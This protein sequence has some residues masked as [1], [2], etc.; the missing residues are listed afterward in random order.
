M[1]YDN[2]Y[3]LDVD[4]VIEAIPNVERLKGNRILI[5]GSTGMIASSVVEVLYRLDER[6]YDI[7]LILA[8]RSRDRI[9]NS[10]SGLSNFKYEY[11]HYDAVETEKL[12]FDADYVIHAASNA[13]PAMFSKEPVETMLANINGLQTLLACLKRNRRGRLLYVS[14]SEVYGKKDNNE[15]YKEDEY[16]SLDILN[17]RACYPQSKR[18][19]ETLCS[20]YLKEYGV[21]SVIVRPGH[22]YGPTITPSDNRASAEFSR[23][24]KN[25][26]NIVM[27]SQ[28]T[29][30]RSYCYTLDCASAVLAV[31]IN[32]DSGEAYNISNKNSIISIRELAELLAQS[33]GVEIVYDTPTEEEERSYCLMDNSSLN[34]EK[35]EKLGWKPR[36]NI[37]E[38]VERTIRYLSSNTM[39]YNKI[40][41]SKKAWGG[42]R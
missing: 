27:K 36:F 42:G 23:K 39:H 15:P 20:C 41:S 34:S 37:N 11:M 2:N 7:S 25:K 16:F 26:E 4:R 22:I 30:L 28:G 31:L 40:E 29:Q 12:S 18:S 5:T 24:A 9:E 6:G 38:G 32:G 35:I 3:W 8:G 10:F 33:G 13:N 19:A 1:R 21:D 14:S 17:P